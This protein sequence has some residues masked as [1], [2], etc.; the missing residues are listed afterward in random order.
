QAA[1]GL[2]GGLLIAATGLWLL[3]QRL[4]G[5]ADH[6]HFDYGD[7]KPGWWQLIALGVGGGIVPCWDALAML[8]LAIA[9]QRLWLGL[10]LLLAFSAGLASVLVAV[11]VGVVWARNWAVARWGDRPR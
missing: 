2:I 5:R 1:L 10:P 7:S 9:A 4:A 8:G 3:M 11:G 6:Y